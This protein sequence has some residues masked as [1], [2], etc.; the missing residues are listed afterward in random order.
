MSNDL[1]MS[2]LD[3]LIRAAASV[4]VEDA[5][6][7]FPSSDVEVEFSLRHKKRMNR[8]FRTRCGI[9]KVP[10]PEVD[11]AFARLFD[12]VITLFVSISDDIKRYRQKKRERADRI[13]LYR[14]MFDYLESHQ[15]A[16]STMK[17]M[18]RTCS[19]IGSEVADTVA[20]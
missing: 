5:A 15:A 4:L 12:G 11:T 19:L 7:S 16:Q 2:K 3:L 1:R 18:V 6:A 13:E 14:R 17:T 20:S 8:L 9:K 10:Y